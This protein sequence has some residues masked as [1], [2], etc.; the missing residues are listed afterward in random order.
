MPRSFTQQLSRKCSWLVLT[1]K[2]CF[3]PGLF[4]T[5]ALGQAMG[6]SH[7]GTCHNG[8]G[9]PG[10][11]GWDRPASAPGDEEGAEMWL[12]GHSAWGQISPRLEF[13]ATFASSIHLCS[14]LEINVDAQIQSQIQVCPVC[15]RSQPVEQPGIYP[16]KAEWR[17]RT[18]T[19]LGAAPPLPE[20]RGHPTRWREPGK[21]CQTRAPPGASAQAGAG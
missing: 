8:T 15:C 20:P 18:V 4:L 14:A 5:A 1:L 3:S 19:S 7:L 2:G 11:R 6:I 16:G 9:R 13:F 10:E 12:P 17:G 21:R